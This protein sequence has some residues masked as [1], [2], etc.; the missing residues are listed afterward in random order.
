LGTAGAQHTL[1]QAS[2]ARVPHGRCCCLWVGG[3]GVFF[4]AER[5][6]GWAS[7]LGVL[8]KPCVYGTSASAGGCPTGQARPACE[9]GA[10]RLAGALP[11]KGTFFCQVVNHDCVNVREQTAE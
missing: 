9:A 11:S 6:G 2:A 8:G 5:A 1:L 4:G 3:K 7:E 10:A